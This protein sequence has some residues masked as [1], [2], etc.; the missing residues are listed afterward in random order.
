MA[1]L[2]ARF[3]EKLKDSG[4]TLN[5][6]VY[7]SE[8]LFLTIV[9]DMNAFTPLQIASLA[10]EWQRSLATAATPTAAVAA[11]HSGR[12]A[13]TPSRHYADAARPAT[14]PRAAP[15]PA[16]SPA[17]VRAQQ[18]H[19]TLG[20]VLRENAFVPPRRSA[21]KVKEEAEYLLTKL[22]AQSGEEYEVSPTEGIVAVEA[23]PEAWRPLVER[24]ARMQQGGRPHTGRRDG[25]AVA[26]PAVELELLWKLC[27][28]A[29][30]RKMEKACVAGAPFA[31]SN[32][33]DAD[34]LCSSAVVLYHKEATR[35][36][37]PSQELGGLF[38]DGWALVAFDVAV[39]RARTVTKDEARDLNANLYRFSM[40]QC[41]EML[42][43][44]DFDAFHVPS[45]N[46]VAVCHMHQL[47][48]RFV[49]FVGAPAPLAAAAA[50][51]EVRRLGD[52]APVVAGNGGRPSRAP[53]AP[54]PAGDGGG[55][56]AL[57]A[58][59]GVSTR[60]DEEVRCAA[61]PKR[62]VEFWSP[63]EKRLLCSHC[64]YY[65]GYSQDNCIPL[66]QAAREEAPRLERWVQNAVT[67]A[68]E[69]KGVFDLFEAARTD[70]SQAHERVRGDVAQA[71]TRLRAR[72]DT[73][74][75]SLLQQCQHKAQ[76]SQSGLQD[77]LSR[78]TAT[79]AFV[80]DVVQD[81]DE[82]VAAYR[83]GVA[84]TGTCVALLRSAQRA[85]G[86]WEPVAIAGY[87]NVHVADGA[88]L[89]QP[90]EDAL[91]AVAHAVASE[92]GSVQLPE[93]IDVNYLKSDCDP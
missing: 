80:K 62:T 39:G 14:A 10:K 23:A 63:T 88:A 22:G 34:G 85:F 12:G 91:K 17:P 58:V 50:A 26:A 21:A 19:S 79:V 36:A 93:A 89:L 55:H 71:F 60:R 42:E 28:P 1:T 68:Q 65:D 49:I 73:L 83:G 81:A 76:H 27:S 5:D 66:E 38:R 18:Q 24:V 77:T 30:L 67:F 37:A 48:P 7:C 11:A 35:L 8:D 44:A 40:E 84:D 51:V 31:L 78:V 43:E 25:G 29:T 20:T 92:A 56:G 90:V 2:W 87:E 82:P 57:V 54:A 13:P 15:S 52:A 72:I 9:E 6:L 75:A 33:D 64:L 3:T 4:Y 46:A 16:P 61:H 70:V 45:R 74:E 86:T 59:G 41:L 47:M 53:P 32:Q 69:I